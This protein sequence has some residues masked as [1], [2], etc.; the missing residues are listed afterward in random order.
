MKKLF[1]SSC[2]C[3]LLRCFYHFCPLIK[4]AF[5]S[6]IFIFVLPFEAAKL[7]TI[8]YVGYFELEYLLHI[9]KEPGVLKKSSCRVKQP[10]RKIIAKYILTK[11]LKAFIFL[12]LYKKYKLFNVTKFI[13]IPP[14]FQHQA[15]SRTGWRMKSSHS[16]LKSLLNDATCYKIK[17]S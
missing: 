10:H 3:L 2:Q 12:I 7:P 4:G 13:S 1:G 17:I 11:S 8:Q 6:I 14:T 5:L 15:V 9:H 16:V